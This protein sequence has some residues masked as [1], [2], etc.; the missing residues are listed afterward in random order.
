VRG[1]PLHLGIFYSKWVLNVLG[2]FVADAHHRG[3]LWRLPE[4][5]VENIPRLGLEYLLEGNPYQVDTVQ[6]LI[7]TQVEYHWSSWDQKGYHLVGGLPGVKI[8][9]AGPA[10]C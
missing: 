6:E 8:P 3:I 4:K 10:T 5:V 7:R 1:D 9:R 2:R